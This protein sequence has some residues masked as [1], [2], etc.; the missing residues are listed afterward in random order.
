MPWLMLWKTQLPD[1]IEC[2]VKYVFGIQDVIMLELQH[3]LLWRKNYK[4]RVKFQGKL[5]YDYLFTQFF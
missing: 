3:K 1:G 4:E 2:V 5:F